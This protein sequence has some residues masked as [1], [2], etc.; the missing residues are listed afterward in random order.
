[1]I[2]RMVSETTYK[3]NIAIE[4]HNVFSA[5]VVY[6]LV[7]AFTTLYATGLISQKT[8]DEYKDK[9]NSMKDNVCYVYGEDELKEYL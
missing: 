1:M 8:Y 2:K 6:R 3:Y 4:E 7:N 5:V 9:M